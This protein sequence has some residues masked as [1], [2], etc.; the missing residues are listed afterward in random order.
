M[1][2]KARNGRLTHPVVDTPRNKTKR[3]AAPAAQRR[4]GLPRGSWLDQITIGKRDRD[5]RNYWRGQRGL[6]EAW[7]SRPTHSFAKTQNKKKL[8]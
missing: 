2:S 1:H 5:F 7:N 8:G 6:P 3:G 4:P